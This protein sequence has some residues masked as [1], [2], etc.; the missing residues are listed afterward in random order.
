MFER[1]TEIL[2]SGTDIECDDSTFVFG[3]GL[4]AQGASS[5]DAVLAYFRSA[6]IAKSFRGNYEIDFL[7]SANAL[8]EI[9]KDEA[10]SQITTLLEKDFQM[11]SARVPR[12]GAIGKVVEIFLAEMGDCR[13]YSNTG[14]ITFRPD[15]TRASGWNAVTC[16]TLDMLVCAVSPVQVAFWAYADDE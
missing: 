13:Y 12:P 16:H 8:R 14:Y 3:F 7:L 2:R 5:L 9:E 1:T 6:P 11:F 10:R 15:G 4:N